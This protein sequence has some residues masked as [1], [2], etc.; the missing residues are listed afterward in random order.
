MALD[1][2]RSRS[3]VCPQLGVDRERDVVLVQLDVRRRALEVVAGGDLA[4]HLV[5]GVHQ[6]LTIEVAHHVE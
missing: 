4:P 5:E 3:G 6:L 2:M 1:S